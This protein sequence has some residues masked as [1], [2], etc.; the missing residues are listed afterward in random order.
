M[1]LAPADLDWSSLILSKGLQI[2][3]GSLDSGLHAIYIAYSPP[4]SIS[5][6]IFLHLGKLDILIVLF[7]RY[8]ILT[9]QPCPKVDQLTS[10]A[11]KWQKANSFGRFSE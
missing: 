11:A 1:V 2:L 3:T 4:L 6:I 7:G 10:L 5:F 9:I 8:P